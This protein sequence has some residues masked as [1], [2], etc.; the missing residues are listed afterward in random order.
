MQ[1]AV[2]HFNIFR[3]QRRWNDRDTI[4]LRYEFQIQI[5]WIER[6]NERITHFYT[7]LEFNLK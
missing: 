6:G 5:W 1:S 7:Q 4:E 2:D 3:L